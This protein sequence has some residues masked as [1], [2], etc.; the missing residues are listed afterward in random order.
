M[1]RSI[2]P[3][4]LLIIL[5][6][7]SA[8]SY[9]DRQLLSA[10]VVDIR[11]DFGFSYFQ[12]SL[13]YGLVFQVSFLIASIPAGVLADRVSRP[14]LIGGAVSLWSLL[15]AATGA[16]S[17]FSQL[18]AV[19]AL[20]GIGEA[21]LTPASIS[22][23]TDAYPRR[24]HGLVLSILYLGVPLGAGG[25]LLV[26]GLLGPW[27]G[28]RG[29]FFALG[30]MGLMT[31]VLLFFI[32]D[33]REL[34]SG[35]GREAGASVKDSLIFMRDCAP[36]RYLLLG[37]CVFFFALG[38]IGLDQAWVVAE[39]GYS[40]REGQLAFGLLI[41]A[42]GLACTWITG[43][44]SDCAARRGLAGR[45]LFL[46]WTALAFAAASVVFRLSPQGSMLFYFGAV[47][48]YALLMAL[49]G[50]FMAAL[51]ELA[52]HRMRSTIVAIGL[53][54]IALLGTTA[55]SAAAGRLSDAL[56]AARVPSP[57]THALLTVNLLAIV[58]AGLFVCAARAVKRTS[59][60]PSMANSKDVLGRA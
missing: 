60:L 41:I 13:L 5:L 48:S 32:S 3:S 59:R 49:F 45:L 7:L 14:R 38:S 33:P 39:R 56:S 20:V 40:I 10:F 11:R 1:S 26:A 50:P 36:L 47:L 8:F 53:V 9:A 44:L 34:S 16:C 54:S 28:W 15:T 30:I 35:V 57:L 27:L 24:R 51:A 52:P 12:F 6:A 46:A 23:L 17:S 19:R 25:S 4:R 55:G 22:M 21:G 42:P 2:R 37:G 43:W 58:A 18:A 31:S 29:C